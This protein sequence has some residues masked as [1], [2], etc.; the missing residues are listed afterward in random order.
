MSALRRRALLTVISATAGSTL[1]GCT[2]LVGNEASERG[3]G[4][5]GGLPRAK[6]A[7][8]AATL[9]VEA[10]AAEQ[11]ERAHER[12]AP[13]G[14]TEFSIGELE[15]SW[16]GYTAVGGTFEEI[17]DT[18]ETVERSFDAVDVTMAFSRGEH[19][20]RILVTDEFDVVALVFNGTYEQPAYVDHDSVAAQEVTLEAEDCAIMGTAVTPTDA[21]TDSVPGVVLVHD[22]R[23]ANRDLAKIATRTFTDLAEGLATQGIA[24]LRYDKRT[25]ACPQ[26]VAPEDH[27]L[28]TVTVDDALVAIDALRTLETVDETRVIVAGLGVGGLAVPRIAARDGSLAGGVAMSAP[29]RPFHKV[30]LEKLEHQATVGAHEWPAMTARYE[31]WSTQIDRLNEGDYGP[32][33]T[34]LGFPGAFWKS[35]DAYGPVA[36]ARETDVPLY[37]L[38]GGRDFQVDADADFG[39]WRSALADRPET[40]FERYDG[41]NHL[42]MPG[43]GPGVGFEYYV[44]NSVDARVVEDLAEWIETL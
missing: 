37:F 9:F 32:T 21:A 10:L 38:Q 13:R 11:Y 1:A 20:L 44:R 31:R 27:T 30:T 19:K 4:R 36:T 23:P 14:P 2:Q 24:T 3:G 17:T 12:I 26:Q 42:L 7:V 28:D 25:Y 35:L 33:D 8:E 5:N 29:A 41:L 22:S 18:S 16:L 39:L 40:S 34:L 43:D 6:T 15:Q